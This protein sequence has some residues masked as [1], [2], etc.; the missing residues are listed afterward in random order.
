MHRCEKCR[1]NPC[2][3]TT[4]VVDGMIISSSMAYCDGCFKLLKTTNNGDGTITLHFGVDDSSDT[5]KEAR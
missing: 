1:E 2:P 3:I 4:T 5:S